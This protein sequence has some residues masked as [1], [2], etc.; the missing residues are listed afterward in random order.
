MAESAA[1]AA[2]AE[3]GLG[4]LFELAP[5]AVIVGDALTGR[6]VRWNRAAEEMFGYSAQEAVGMPMVDI[7]ADELVAPLEAGIARYRQEGHTQL[8]DSQALAEI[9]GKHKDGHLVWIEL[10]LAG[11]DPSG[12][13]VRPILAIARNITERRLAQEQAARDAQALEAAHRALREFVAI[14]AHDLRGPLSAV[15]SAVKMVESMPL[16]PEERS[17]LLAIAVR[18]TAL[19]SRLLDD[20][21]DINQIESGHV[22]VR[23]SVFPLRRAVDDALSPSE[24]PVSVSVPEGLTVRA[25]PAHV[26]RIITNLLTNARRYGAEPFEISATPTG[27]MVELRFRDSGPG[28]PAELAD[29]MF[30]KFIRGEGS[31]GMGLGLAISRGL[32]EAGGGSLRL[33]AAASGGACFVLS[34]PAG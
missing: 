16:K 29:R 28:V 4:R 21:V 11:L 14:T 33:D 5:D 27:A 17:E 9:P 15:S 2:E 12:T 31:T 25:D 23:A 26:A 19:M 18:Q 13:E 32:A 20:L 7:V 34:L 6:I 3:L 10:R 8:V 1:D 22:V 30:S 24:G